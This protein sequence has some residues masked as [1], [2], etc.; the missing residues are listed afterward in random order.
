VECSDDG[1]PLFLHCSLFSDAPPLGS[2]T[3]RVVEVSRLAVS[4]KYNRRAGD[5][6]YGL[7]GGP[8][9]ANPQERREGGEI[10][11]TLYKTLYQVSKRRGFTHWLAATERSLQRLVAKYGF[12]FEAVGPESD[13]HGYVSP[14]LMSLHDFDR[15]I[16]SRQ[17]PKLDDFLHGLESEFAPVEGDALPSCVAGR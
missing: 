16:L 6:F 7:Q 2:V 10:V 12:P 5:G 3:Q 8:D 1:L 17:F 15:V 13:Y 9:R 14:Y 11:L 4:R